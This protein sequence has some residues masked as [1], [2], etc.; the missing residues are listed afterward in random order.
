MALLRERL[1]RL[2]ATERARRLAGPGALVGGLLAGTGDGL[3]GVGGH[4]LSRLHAHLHALTWVVGELVEDGPVVVVVDD[5]QWADSASLQ[6]LAYLA[7]RLEDVPLK[8]LLAVTSGPEPLPEPLA[9]LSAA[10]RTEHVSLAPLTRQGVPRPS[11][12]RSASPCTRGSRPPA[13]TSSGGNPLL[14]NELLLELRRRG[15]RPDS[16][17]VNAARELR[18]EGLQRRIA[19]RV[20]ALDDDAR[21]AAEALAVLESARLDQIAALAHLEPRAAAVAVDRLFAADI[22]T[23]ERELSFAHALVRHVVVD[24]LGPGSGPACTATPRPCCR[25]RARD[26]SASRRC[27]VRAP[28]ALDAG[29]IESLHEAAAGALVRG[30]PAIASALLRRALEE[31]AAGALRPSLAGTLGIAATAAGEP[32]GLELLVAAAD[33]QPDPSTA[34]RLRVRAAHGL[35]MSRG[36]APALQLLEAT[37]AADLPVEVASEVRAT[38]IGAANLDPNWSGK[39]P[40]TADTLLGPDEPPRS[41]AE[42]AMLASGALRG[43]FTG[44]A[45]PQEAAALALRGYDDGPDRRRRRPRRRHGLVRDR[46]AAGQR[47]ARTG[48]RGHRGAAATRAPLRVAAGLRQRGLPARLP[49]VLPR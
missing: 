5:A 10:P 46:R 34:A 14:L 38:M 21:R 47:R 44:Q 13:P 2:P 28:G 30:T 48:P 16:G 8:L 19:A 23:G 33:L 27:L 3:D 31:P 26:R 17:A 45:S 35:L 11:P 15:L 9:E 4:E 36:A 6:W 20:N 41:A 24:G 42:R 12:R 37:L 32:D 7:A 22:V 49:A 25:R 18:P 29:A 1:G 39:L 40:F 43:L